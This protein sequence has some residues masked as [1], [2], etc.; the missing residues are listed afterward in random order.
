MKKI[1]VNPRVLGAMGDDISREIYQKRVAYGNGEQEAIE[2]IINLVWGGVKL[3][4]FMQENRDHLYVFGAGM[5]GQDLVETWNWK[6]AFQGFIDN[7][8]E[9]QGKKIKGIPIMALEELKE[10]KEKAAIIIMNKFYHQEIAEQLEKEGFD[11]K[12]VFNFGS[13]YRELNKAQYFDLEELEIVEGEKFVDCGV[14]DGE[15]SLNL[16]EKYGNK[17]KK[18][19]MFEPDKKNIQKVKN[20]FKDQYVEYEIIEKGVWSSATTLRFQS[21]GNGCSGIEEN[22]EER[23]ETICLDEVL[24]GC[25][26][27]FIKMD[28][29]GAEMEALKGAETIIR[30]YQPK[31]AISIYHKLEDIEEIPK[32]L[33]EYNRTYKFY[34]RHYSLMSSETILYAL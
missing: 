8:K 10:K 7:D 15:T 28:I 25:E 19:W 29:E 23:I 2:P 26:P 14:L 33:L 34:I 31:L 9:K 32:L 18:I 27:T 16:L 13:L 1:E 6:Y 21:L 3:L 24:N 22:G 5:I 4:A 30:K 12:K 11:K 20:N 17:I